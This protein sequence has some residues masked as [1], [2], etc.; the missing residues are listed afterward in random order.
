LLAET[1]SNVFVRDSS[2]RCSEVPEIGAPSNMETQALTTFVDEACERYE[3]LGSHYVATFT[4]N[5][6]SEGTDIRK[7]LERP[8]QVALGSAAGTAGTIIYTSTFTWGNLDTLTMGRLYGN[9]GFRCKLRFRLMVAASPFTGGVFKMLWLP[10]GCRAPNTQT[11]MSMAPGVYLDISEATE[12]IL[13]VP[14]VSQVDFASLLGGSTTVYGTFYLVAFT[15]I[16]NPS[17][18]S[19]AQYTLYIS[20]HDIDLVGAAPNSFGYSTIVPNAGGEATAVEKPVSSMLRAAAAV[21]TLIGRVP[22]LSSLTVPVSWWLNASANLASSFGFSKPMLTTPTSRMYV[23][24]NVLA[25][26]IDAADTSA[27]LAATF[28]NELEVLPGFAGTDVDEMALGFVL[29]RYSAINRFTL[30]TLDVANSLKYGCRLSPSALYFGTNVPYNT[31]NMF[32]LTTTFAL[33][34]AVQ[35]SYVA[36]VAN[37]FGYWKG[38]LVFKF[39]SNKTKLH[40]GRLLIAHYPFADDVGS[41]G[42]GLT[43][44]TTGPLLQTEWHSAVWDLRG[45]NTFEFCCPYTY[46]VP[47]A[48]VT[49]GIGNLLVYALEPLIAASTVS[50][51]IEITVQVRGGDNFEFA[52]PVTPYLVPAPAG[53]TLTGQAGGTPCVLHGTSKEGDCKHSIGERL[54][55]IKQL[56]M[57]SCSFFVATGGNAFYARSFYD[58][59][60]QTYGTNNYGSIAIPFCWY[61]SQ[62]YNFARGSTHYDIFDMQGTT[63]S[64]NISA[65]YVNTHNPVQTTFSDNSVQLEPS[66]MHVRMPYNNTA[67][68]DLVVVGAAAPTF[69]DSQPKPSTCALRATGPSSFFIRAGDDSQLGFLYGTP[70]L[71]LVI[72]SL[73]NARSYEINYLAVLDT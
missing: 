54:L 25:Q 29:S 2:E 38:D 17:G 28:A 72:S 50:T 57:K 6:A 63:L 48:P 18:N 15:S 39:M 36:Y 71:G 10:G 61:Y 66:H 56:I 46:Y 4:G 5:N 31:Y 47:Y 34:Q 70:Y 26:N 14:W 9:F 60:A 62:M 43:A 69:V 64:T 21:S 40:A 20:L 13:D 12:A 52:M 65:Y 45:D 33:K 41:E 35:P 16:N 44:P 30:S 8:Q 23:T 59:T 37:T 32:G 49:L 19:Q 58:V 1:N 67:P 11:A 24:T 51:S 53:A 22:T 42:V 3:L 73:G 68:R 27:S 55:S 7:F